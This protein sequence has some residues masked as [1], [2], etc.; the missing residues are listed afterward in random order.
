MR[1]RTLSLS[2]SGLALALSLACGGGSSTP[3][4]PAAPEAPAATSLTYTDPT[5]T[6]WRLVKDPASTATHLV[7]NL[8]GPTGAMTRGVGFNLQAPATVKFE[9]FGNGLA[10]EDAGVYELQSATPGPLDPAALYGGVK[11]GNI[12]TVGIFQKDRAFA[13]KDSGTTLA[14]IALTLN[15]ANKPKVGDTLALTVLKAKVIPQD[16][17]TASDDLYTLSR[18]MRMADIPL[19]VGTLTAH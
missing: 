13:A 8:V 7:L 16:I 15:A 6:G 17:G 18:K 3:S 4:A 9:A 10:L 12:L 11:T 5:G 14:R 19:A 2:C 1:F